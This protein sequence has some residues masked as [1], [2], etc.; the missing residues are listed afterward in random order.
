MS[1]QY[2][3]DGRKYTV[4][5]QQLREE[6]HRFTNMDDDVF[7]LNIP[8]ALHLACIICWLKER[9]HTCLGDT[10]IIHQLVHL[11]TNP[12]TEDFH[13]IRKQFENELTLAL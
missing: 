10:G 5:Y 2:S 7:R 12:E 6:H 11:L 4:S 13:A 1:I 9:S 3:L 8:D